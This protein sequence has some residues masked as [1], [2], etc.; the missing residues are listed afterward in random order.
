M[1]NTKERILE[2]AIQLFNEHGLINVRLQHI[3]DAAGISVGNLAYH[4]PDKTAIVRG[5]DARLG[6]TI[7]PML[8]VDQRFPQLIDFDN[9]LSNYYH[10][11][12][13]YAFYFLDLLELE[14]A[15]PKLH[16]KRKTYIEQMLS[17]I[18][19]WMFLNVEKGVLQP[20]LEEGQ[21]RQS[22]HTI[23]MIITFWLTQHQ[24]RGEVMEGEGAFKLAVWNQLL[25][26]FTEIGLMEY[27]ALILPQLRNHS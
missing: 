10:L 19:Q 12:Q 23:W 8:Y 15:Y 27:Q 18:E 21:Y 1:K 11:V 13:Q 22:A 25:P 5:I 9:Q 6:A 7:T 4:F 24:V 2:S 17:Q 3:A 26:L 14:R 16:S 20:E